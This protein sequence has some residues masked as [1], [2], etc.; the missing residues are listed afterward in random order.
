MRKLHPAAALNMWGGFTFKISIIP[1]FAATFFMLGFP[2]DED[3]N[4]FNRLYILFYPGK[5]QSNVYQ[6]KSLSDALGG[7]NF[8]LILLAIFVVVAIIAAIMAYLYYRRFEYEVTDTT[9]Q[10][11]GG[12]FK[13]FDISVTFDKIQHINLRRSMLDRALGISVLHINTAG[14]VSLEE[15]VSDA[16]R[17]M[18]SRRNLLYSVYLLMFGRAEFFIPGIKAKE[19]DALLEELINKTNP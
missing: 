5:Y 12:L 11:S 8:F 10:I 14:T 18:K 19:A 17:L 7:L 16:E 15:Q 9:L 4:I 2:I 3:L 13:K 1:L 6:G